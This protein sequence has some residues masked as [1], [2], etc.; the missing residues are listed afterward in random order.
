MCAI[1][2]QVIKIDIIFIC[3]HPCTTAVQGLICIEA[4]R[5]LPHSVKIPPRRCPPFHLWP[6]RFIFLVV[7]NCP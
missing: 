5:V 7:F 3:T 6:G 4:M 1:I 2:S